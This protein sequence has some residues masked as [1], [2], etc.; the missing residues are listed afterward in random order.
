MLR[1]SRTSN[2]PFDC[3][4]AC[5]HG[6]IIIVVLLAGSACEKDISVDIPDPE[7]KLVVEG[8]IEQGRPPFVF[9]TQNA[10]Y[11]G[12]TN[13]NQLDSFFVHDATITVSNGS[14]TDTLQE[15]CLENLPDG[16]AQ[17]E[18]AQSFGVPVGE[19]GEPPNICIYTVEDIQQFFLNPSSYNG[20]K[21]ELG[22]NYELTVHAEGDTLQANDRL[23]ELMPIDSLSYRFKENSDT[24]ISVIVNLRE[25]EESGNFIRYFTKRN[26]EPFYPPQG[27]SVYD[28]NFFSGQYFSLPIERGISNSADVEFEEFGYFYRGDTVVLKWTHIT[29]EH[30]DFWSTLEYEQGNSANPFSSPTRINSNI[31]GGLGV[32]GGY[33]ADYDTIVLPQ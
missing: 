13:V 27:G 30:Y 28:D 21:G 6:L 11:F 20:F 17:E 32:W 25:P 9:L 16:A 23:R 24:L 1:H 19:E 15:L 5:R 22:T 14:T 12:K 3:L 2:C 33:A 18:F 7:D 26:S 29:K 10:A 8:W 4:K 31:D